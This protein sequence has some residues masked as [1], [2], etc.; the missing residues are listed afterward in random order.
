MKAAG[1][2]DIKFS[3]TLVVLDR[4]QHMLAY[5]REQIDSD[6]HQKLLQTI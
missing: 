4:K 2:V 6:G 3:S 5:L 1:S